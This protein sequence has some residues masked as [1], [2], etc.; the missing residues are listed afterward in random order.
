MRP[1]LHLLSPNLIGWILDEAFQLLTEPG[2]RVLYPPARRLLAEAGAAVDEARAVVRLPERAVRTALAT[3][4]AAFWL[5]DRSGEPAVRYGGNAVHFDPGSCGVHVLD[6]ATGAHRLAETPDLVRVLQVAQ[7]LPAYDAVSTALVCHDVPTEIGDLYRL[8]VVLLYATKPV[9]TGAFAIPTTQPMLDMLALYAG[10]AAAL[11]EKPR[12][13]FD[14]CPTPPLTWGEFAAHNLM[15]LARA[16]VPVEMVSMPLAGVAAPV[17]L[18]GAVVQHTAE[19]L[20]GLTIH[21]L[22]KPGAPI[23]WGGAP[24]IFDMRAGTTPMG[25]IETAM[26]DAVYAEVGKSLE[27]PT[28]AYL[29]ASDAKTLDYQSGLESGMTA[30]VGA[31]AG[32]NMISGAGM[33]DFLACV[34]VEKLVLDADAIGMAKRMARGVEPLTETLAT[35]LF[36]GIDFKP[37]FLKRRETRA[38]FAREQFRPSAAVDR[39]S[40]RAWQDGGA[41]DA[42]QRAGEMVQRLVADYVRPA[43]APE[44]ERELTGMVARLAKRAGMN[45]LPPV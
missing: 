30:L 20:A 38:L 34:S 13:V 29:G 15:T 1:A 10:G 22:A 26:L 31:L 39:G 14:V 43:A 24:A 42:A 28:H 41:Q 35:A 37:D 45:A 17:T 3:V 9:V 6:A 18:L 8:Y 7:S 11:A 44:L 2:I 32:I 21:Q 16:G 33:L 5:H 19:S 36:S 23:V 27:L 12:A 40:I 25:A 4:P